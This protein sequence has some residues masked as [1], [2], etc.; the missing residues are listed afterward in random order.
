MNPFMQVRFRTQGKFRV[1]QRVHLK[2]GG[3]KDLVAEIIED[4][5]PLGVGGSRVYR[6]LLHP[7]QWNDFET[8]VPEEELELVEDAPDAAAEGDGKR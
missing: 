7:D 5:G 8:E 4:R 1:G 2:Y 6:I 3:F